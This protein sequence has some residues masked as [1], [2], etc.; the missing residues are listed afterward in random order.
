MRLRPWKTL[1]S[2]L[3]STEV[4]VIQTAQPASRLGL[5]SRPFT[6]MALS[7]PRASTLNRA[8]MIMVRRGR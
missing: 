3:S 7:T 5:G 2:T 4:W 8:A 1:T 6:S